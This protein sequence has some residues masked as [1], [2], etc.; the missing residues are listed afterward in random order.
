[1]DVR[2]AAGVVQHADDPGRAL[3][4]GRR[5]AEA[6]DELRVARAAADGARARVRHIREQRAEGDDEVDLELLHEVDDQARERA[7]AQV[8][9]DAE[10]QDDVTVEAIRTAVVED[11]RGPVDPPREARLERDVRPGRLEVEEGLRVDLRE[12]LRVPELGE[13]AGGERGA[14]AAVVPAPERG[15]H[16]RPLE[17]RA[18][19]DTEFLGH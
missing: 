14:L 16:E 15:D 12:A 3:V 10:E 18:P 7:P 19:C 11:G 4:A 1:M 6:L 5:E 17:L 8:R 13:V 2:L 9:L